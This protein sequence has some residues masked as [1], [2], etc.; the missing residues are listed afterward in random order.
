MVRKAQLNRPLRK[1]RNIRKL[2][3]Q[4]LATDKRFT[5]FLQN[6]QIRL[7]IISFTLSL[8]S[9]LRDTSLHHHLTPPVCVLYAIRYYF[10]FCC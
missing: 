8:L 4:C 7:I 6:F 1:P 9:F 5:E 3:L 2:F 10:V